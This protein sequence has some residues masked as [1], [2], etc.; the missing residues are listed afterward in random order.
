MSLLAARHPGS[1]NSS[2]ARGVNAN[3]TVNDEFSR[4]ADLRLHSAGRQ[5]QMPQGPLPTFIMTFSGSSGMVFTLELYAEIH[6]SA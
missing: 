3:H 1:S 4:A 6:M 2:S 5:S